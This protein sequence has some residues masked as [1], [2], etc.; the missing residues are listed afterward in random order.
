MIKCQTWAGFA[1]TTDIF[2]IVHSNSIH[3]EDK[4]IGQ[5]LNNTPQTGHKDNTAS[6]VQK[7][8]ILTVWLLYWDHMY[9]FKNCLLLTMVQ[10][11]TKHHWSINDWWWMT[12]SLRRPCIGERTHLD[13]GNVSTGAKQQH[14][15]TQR[16]DGWVTG[17]PVSEEQ[18]R[19]GALAAAWPLLHT[20]SITASSSH[21]PLASREMPRVARTY[22]R[23]LLQTAC[24][25]RGL[26]HRSKQPS[27]NQRTVPWFMWKSWGGLGAHSV[28]AVGRKFWKSPWRWRQN[29]EL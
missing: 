27:K 26:L 10:E 23:D 3:C 13:P 16:N 25:L 1:S 18:S 12:D 15:V 29:T 5:R 8:D 2:H 20:W 14:E 11:G 21:L 22:S 19:C 28:T 17:D 7:I 4:N 24:Y 9:F 6:I